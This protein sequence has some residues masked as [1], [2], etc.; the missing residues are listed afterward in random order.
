[1][2]IAHEC[3]G[4]RNRQ[5]CLGL[6]CK[7]DFEKAYDMVDWSFL[8][9]MLERVRFGSK[10]RRRIQSCVHFSPML[11]FSLCHKLHALM[12]EGKQEWLITGF[13]IDNVDYEVNHLQ[14]A[15]DTNF[16]F[17]KPR[18]TKWIL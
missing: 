1:M 8:Q 18:W 10:W 11:F 6:V 4:S 9:Y 3:V 12:G 14:F 17:V 15:Y 7:L 16:F 5:K 13:P 2:V